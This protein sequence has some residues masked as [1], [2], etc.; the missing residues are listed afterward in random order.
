MLVVKGVEH[1]GAHEFPKS[2]D[3][4]RRVSDDGVAG[5]RGQAQRHLVVGIDVDVVDVVDIVVIVVVISV[6][7][8]MDTV[9]NDAAVVRFAVTRGQQELAGRN[10]KRGVF[11][12]LVYLFILFVDVALGVGLMGGWVWLMGDGLGLPGAG[13]MGVLMGG[14]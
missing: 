13:L 14:G 8:A 9:G 3:G 1:D 5:S 11:V 6:V 12:C 10:V 2:G 4:D 7:V